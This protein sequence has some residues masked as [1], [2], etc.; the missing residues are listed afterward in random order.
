[1][2]AAIFDF[3]GTLVN[4]S[5]FVISHMIATC[6]VMGVKVPTR[7][8]ILKVLRM[9]L[10][11]EEVFQHLFAKYRE[12]AYETAFKPI[13]G[14]IKFTRNLAEQKIPLIIATNRIKM[15]EFRLTQAGFKKEWF[16]KMEELEFKKP[17]PKAFLKLIETFEK[18]GKSRGSIY[19]FGDH[20]DD[21]SSC[22]RDLKKN[23]I[24]LTT[25][26]ISKE[27][28]ISS[29]VN[30]EIIFKDFTEIKV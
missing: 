17:S 15:L 5:E 1:M 25:G 8:E 28:F 18:L 29:G 14:A 11:F 9:N 16:Y 20:L 10:L 3:D 7:A 24:A 23:F 4:S 30:K 19:I 13:D 21:F 12:T 6:R 22:P 27:E 26:I 2:D